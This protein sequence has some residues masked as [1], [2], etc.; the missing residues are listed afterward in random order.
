MADA[1]PMKTPMVT[2]LKLLATD[3][4]DA[5]D[6]SLYRSVVGALQYVTLT[7]PDV[8]FA[9]NKVCQFMHAPKESY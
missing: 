8:A 3:S 4:P 6:A 2:G 7:R 5:A 1:N 9:V